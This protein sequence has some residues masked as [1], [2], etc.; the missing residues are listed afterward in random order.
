MRIRSGHVAKKVF[1]TYFVY[2]ETAELELP[3]C[4]HLEFGHFFLLNSKSLNTNEYTSH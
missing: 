1:Q 4:S 2:R 3:V